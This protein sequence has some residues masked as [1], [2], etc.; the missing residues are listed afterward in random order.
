MGTSYRRAP[1]KLQTTLFEGDE[2]D[3]LKGDVTLLRLPLASHR[4]LLVG[5]W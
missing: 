4:S 5:A 1:N 3:A 2:L